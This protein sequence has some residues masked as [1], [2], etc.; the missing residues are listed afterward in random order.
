LAKIYGPFGCKLFVED[1]VTLNSKNYGYHVN[2]HSPVKLMAD[3]P[4]A[5]IRIRAKS[6]IHG[7]CLH[8]HSSITIGRNCLIA[9]NC[10]IFDGNGH[11]L[12]FP[13][14][15]DRIHTTGLSKPIVIED[16]VWIGANYLVLPRVRIGAGSV[17]SANSVVAQDIP[18]MVIVRGNRHKL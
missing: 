12:S 7:T 1:G 6:R 11:D 13:N 8:A 2:V 18:P 4:G 14:V 16:N 5:V 17:I 9:A 15:E 3:R 10:Q